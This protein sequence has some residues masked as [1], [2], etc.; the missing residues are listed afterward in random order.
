MATTTYKHIE[1]NVVD[2]L[3]NLTVLYPANKSTD[4]AVVSTNPNLQSAKTLE[5][6]LGKLGTLAFKNDLSGVIGEATSSQAGLM[7]AADKAKLDKV[8]ANEMGYLAG[9][10]SN[11]QTQLDGKAAT[12]HVHGNITADGKIGAEGNK[13]ITTGADGTLQATTQNSAFN[14]AFSDAVPQVAAGSG[15][16]GVSTDVARADHSHP[17][18]TSV[19][20]NAGTATKL[21]TGRMING[22]LF[23]GTGD[24]TTG[25]WGTAR[26]ITVTGAVTG[27]AAGV[28]GSGDITIT[29]ATVDAS[30][31]TGTIDIARLPQTALERLY[32]AK[33]DTARLALTTAEVQNGDVVKVTETGK[34]YYVKDDTKLGGD[35]PEQAFEEFAA[36]T[37]ASVPWS[38]IT[39]KPETFKP[40]AHTHG[41]LTNDG[42]LGD[43][44][45]M[46]VTTGEGGAIQAT[47]AGSAFNKNFSDAL[48]QAAAGVASAGSSTDVA[49]ADHV[50]PLQTSVSGN[51]GT[52]TK[53]AAPVQI[54]GTAFDGS[55][56]ITTEKWGTAR[57][58][59]L[60]GDVTGTVS[61]DGSGD[62]SITTTVDK[63]KSVVVQEVQPEYA[64]MWYKVTSTEGEE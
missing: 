51:A 27:S 53:L 40:E 55:A 37:A 61:A 2:A 36:G 58:I 5:D 25:K 23:D 48:P 60:T 1:M 17:E 56:P 42:K 33:N 31:L 12:Q 62:I 54:N 59:T 24:I 30:K 39:G 3:G 13:V 18:Q 6:V 38:G 43:T 9:V 44:A 46:V 11:I 35:T 34:M 57:N 19:S 63:S 32:V 41:A 26:N 10:T 29:T 22:T 49:R 28:D 4:V 47:A 7:P 50:H 15:S 14:K 45:G 20:G 8:S 64:C 21:E 16:A 52:A